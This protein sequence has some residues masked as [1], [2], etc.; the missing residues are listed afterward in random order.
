MVKR[1]L[2]G[3]ISRELVDMTIEQYIYKE[4]LRLYTNNSRVDN[5]ILKYKTEIDFKNKVLERTICETN[6][7]I[8]KIVDIIVLSVLS[9]VYINHDK[10]DI[11]DHHLD[12]TRKYFNGHII[13][14][15]NN[16]ITIKPTG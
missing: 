3:Y 15:H 8:F 6:H 16:I 9:Y 13:K 5:I 1:I 11:H 14:M 4:L 12:L 10:L 7:T 2:R